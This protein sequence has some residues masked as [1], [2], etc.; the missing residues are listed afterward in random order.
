MNIIGIDIG[1][2][3]TKVAFIQDGKLIECIVDRS[4]YRFKEVGNQLFSKIL[5]KYHLSKNDIQKIISTGY[6]RHTID[7]ADES[8]TEITA[9][10]RGVQ[11]FFPEVRSIIDIGGQDSK[12]IIINPKTKKVLDFQMNDKCAAGT[13]RF[14]EVMAHALEVEISQL[15]VIS[16]KSNNPK[17]ISSMCTVF[18]ESEVISLFAQGAKKEDIA[19]GIHKAIAKR[20]GSM[21]KRLDVQPPIV[22]CGGVAKNPAVKKAL[23]GELGTEILSPPDP[24][25]TGAVGAALIA[26]DK[27]NSK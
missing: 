2:L 19:A 4:T 6:G 11:Y 15:G 13:G 20:V 1:S 9:H 18:A 16:L 24:Q 3:S 21:A 8:V 10:A 27:L 14:L 5:E 23:E 12:A 17:E 22:F 26:Y 7:I 25:I